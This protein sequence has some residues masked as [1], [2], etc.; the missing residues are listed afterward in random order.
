[1]NKH[2]KESK[3]M[4]KLHNQN[5]KQLKKLTINQLINDNY[6]I[7]KSICTSNIFFSDI[8]PNTEENDNTDV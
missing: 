2:E 6:K 8:F 7:L 1:M 3:K 5:I 4:L